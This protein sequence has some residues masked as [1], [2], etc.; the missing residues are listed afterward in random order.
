MLQLQWNLDRTVDRGISLALDFIK[1]AHDD[2]VQPIAL[3]ACERFGAT[4]PICQQTRRAIEKECCLQRENI[5]ISSVKALIIP[6]GGIALEKLSTN[7]AGLNFLALATSLVSVTTIIDSSDTIQRMIEASAG[8]PNLVPPEYH[9]R[10]IL[11]VL[12]PRLNRVG[13]LDRCYETEHWLKDLIDC[14]ERRYT[15]PSAIGISSIVTTLRTLLR[16]GEDQVGYVVFTANTCSAWLIT[17][18]EWCIG[19][20]P[21]IY[22]SDGSPINVEPES[23]IKVILPVESKPSEGIGIE[24]FTSANDLFDTL[25]VHQ[26]VDDLGKPLDLVG[27]VSIRIHAEQL[28]RR[29]G[30]KEEF[31]IRAVMQGLSYAIT[32]VLDRM[33]PI[34]HGWFDE[35]IKI[36]P[37]SAEL[38][39]DAEVIQNTIKTYFGSFAKE[40][41]GIQRLAPGSRLSDVPVLRQWAHK[42]G[43]SQPKSCN[44]S[45]DWSNTDSNNKPL[46]WIEKFI[47]RSISEILSVVLTLSTIHS[48]LEE[49]R[50]F[51]DLKRGPANWTHDS[52]DPDLEFPNVISP[53][54]K[55]R[56]LSS[57]LV[58]L[59]QKSTQLRWTEHDVF[60]ELVALLNHKGILTLPGPSGGL[61]HYL[62]TS[63]HGQVLF[64]SLML[65]MRLEKAPRTSF[66]CL[67]GVFSMK[68]RPKGEHFRSLVSSKGINVHPQPSPGIP[69]SQIGNLSRFASLQHE[70][71]FRI[72]PGSVLV[73]L[74]LKDYQGKST[75]VEPWLV[76]AGRARLKFAPSCNHPQGIIQEETMEDYE[77]VHPDDFFQ[78]GRGTS[79]ICVYAVRGNDPLRLMIIG[80]L[81]SVLNG[82]GSAVFSRDACLK[83]SLDLCREKN[84]HYLIC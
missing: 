43:Q 78:G 57:E 36:D 3:M 83:C 59:F 19:H 46:G 82:W 1:I 48:N 62:G 39:S 47:N 58:G 23:K 45:S 41:P 84:A 81:D 13:F 67:P 69:S 79:K 71:N 30:V 73:H 17:F 54:T 64:F 34:A 66:M 44:N 28:L 9:I 77:F 55:H 26:A 51:S 22:S 49:V 4:L 29:F 56:K 12:E 15:I 21:T 7:M 65:E 5:V 74:S 60:H 42:C 8:D 72:I 33:T 63:D 10:R 6:A 11:E 52:S 61:Q 16:V 20:R 70:W 53:N 80:A 35:T 24:T 75:R 32:E 31:E 18:I 68:G 76:I 38:F 40:F 50:L 25:R 14:G 37:N 2:N 27:L